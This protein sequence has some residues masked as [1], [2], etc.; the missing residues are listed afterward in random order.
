VPELLT[1]NL[2]SLQVSIN[3]VETMTD[4]SG[5]F[6]PLVPYNGTIATGGDS[7]TDDLNVF[8]NVRTAHVPLA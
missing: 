8:Y 7:L 1:R 5:N 4:F 6:V 2:S 3:P